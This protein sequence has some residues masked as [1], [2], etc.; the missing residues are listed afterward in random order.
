MGIIKL[1]AAPEPI[2]ESHK[3]ALHAYLGVPEGKKIPESLLHE[4]MKTE[5]DPKRRKQ[6]N[7]AL[8]ARH[9]KH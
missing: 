4:K 2:K 7:Y 3:G 6:I 1:A 5:T 9:W 8:V